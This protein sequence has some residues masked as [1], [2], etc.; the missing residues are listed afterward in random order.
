[1]QLKLHVYYLQIYHIHNCL[2]ISPPNTISKIY[3]LHPMFILC[4]HPMQR[5]LHLSQLNFILSLAIRYSKPAA[6]NLYSLVARPGGG[7]NR[8]MQV[9]SWCT[10]VS[11]PSACVSQVA[12]CT[13]VHWPTTCASQVVHMHQPGSKLPTARE[14]GPLFQ[15]IKIWILFPSY[16]TLSTYLWLS[17]NLRTIPFTSSFN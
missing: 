1:M 3:I 9:A 12:H 13:Y 8:P 7:G 10:C 4:L 16:T 14:W 6:L 5:I 15:T 11:W 17:S 2:Q